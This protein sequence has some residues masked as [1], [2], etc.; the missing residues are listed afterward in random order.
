MVFMIRLSIVPSHLSTA[1]FSTCD[2]KFWH[3]A[4]STFFTLPKQLILVYLGVLLL[5]GKSSFWVKFGLFGVAGVVTVASGVWIYWKMRAIKKDLVAKQEL[6][7]ARLALRRDNSYFG[8][9]AEMRSNNTAVGGGAY[10]PRFEQEQAD[11]YATSPYHRGDSPGGFVD[12][13]LPPSTPSYEQQQRAHEKAYRPFNEQPT[14][15]PGSVYY[16]DGNS[17]GGDVGVAYGQAY[18]TPEAAYPALSP[19]YQASVQDSPEQPLAHKPQGF[20]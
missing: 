5:G 10:A 19:V 18:S 1:V 11:L 17:V 6:K 7:R 8:S 3:F 2:V 9:A 12:S 14:T 4:V 15:V 13:P 20:V 16:A